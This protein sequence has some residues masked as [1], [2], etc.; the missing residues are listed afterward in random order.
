MLSRH[1][2]NINRRCVK[3]RGYVKGASEGVLREDVM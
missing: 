3:V 1:V 2:V